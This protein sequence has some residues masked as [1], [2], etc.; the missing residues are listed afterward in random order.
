M[1]S[2]RKYVTG[3]KI[4]VSIDESTDANGCFMSNIVIGTLKF[5]HP[6]KIF[7]LT[8][9]ILEKDNQSAIAKLLDKFKFLL[10]PDRIRHDM[11]VT[12][13]QFREE[14][15]TLLFNTIYS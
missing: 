9:E 5:A 12:K 11:A 1:K 6:G 10:W 8:T 2:T 3:K 15:L 4:W 13:K 7:S 14:G